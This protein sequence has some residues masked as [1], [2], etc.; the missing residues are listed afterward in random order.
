ME[1]TCKQLEELTK[2]QSYLNP[3]YLNEMPVYNERVSKLESSYVQLAQRAGSFQG[4]LQKMLKDY[5]ELVDLLSLKAAEWDSA[6][7]KLEDKVNV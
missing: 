2:L 7:T 4:R 1:A 6:L 3:A 5:N